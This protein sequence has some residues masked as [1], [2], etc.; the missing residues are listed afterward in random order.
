MKT[1]I[2]TLSV[3]LSALISYAFWKEGSPLFSALFLIP[4]GTVLSAEFFG[5]IEE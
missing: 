2:Q 3:I 4:V 1:L 5:L